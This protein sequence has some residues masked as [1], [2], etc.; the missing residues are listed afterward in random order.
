MQAKFELER[1]KE[2]HDGKKNFSDSHSTAKEKSCGV[3]VWECVERIYM[4]TNS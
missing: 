3:D 4:K 1:P 2:I